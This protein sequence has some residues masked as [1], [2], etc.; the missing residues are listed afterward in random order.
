[1]E[2]EIARYVEL[3]DSTKVQHD[4]ILCAVQKLEES[5]A[6]PAVGRLENWHR[7]LI[8]DLVPV[9]QAVLDHCQKA[10]APGG[11]VPELEIE[12]GGRPRAL[13]LVADEHRALVRDI[14]LYLASLEELRR[15]DEVRERASN[16]TVRLREHQA[17]EA[18]L[19]YEAFCRDIGV[20]D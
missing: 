20:G 2:T 13:R 8:Q 4:E 1:M 16:L 18:D 6:S 10:E 19:I 17:H 15:A 14:G 12:L 3:S 7:R 5:L 9:A 11:L